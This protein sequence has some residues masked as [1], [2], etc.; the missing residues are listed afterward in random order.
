MPQSMLMLK[1]IYEIY[2]EYT[3]THILFGNKTKQFSQ[4]EQVS[5]DMSCLSKANLQITVGSGIARV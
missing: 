4:H 2:N 5:G 1:L 3:T